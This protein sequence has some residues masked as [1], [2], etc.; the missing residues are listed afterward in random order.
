[1]IYELRVYRT[2]PGQLPRLL[3]RFRNHT[4][5]I[6]DRLGIRTVGFWITAVGDAEGGE[7]TYMLVWDSFA[8]REARW[9]AFQADSQWIQAKAQSES[10]GYLVANIRNQLLVPTNFSALK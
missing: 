5:Q 9:G 4:L 8:D 3:E 6:W 10:E 1:M 7:L 2:L